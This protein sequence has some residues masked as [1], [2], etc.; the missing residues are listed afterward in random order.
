VKTKT[1]PDKPERAEIT[2]RANLPKERL[3]ALDALR[4]LTVAVM[5]M[6]NTSGDAQ[7][8][9]PILA[10]SRWN[11]SSLAD[12]VR[13][14]WPLT[15]RIHFTVP[16]WRNNGSRTISYS[17]ASGASSRMPSATP[18]RWFEPDTTS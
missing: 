10:H 1:L 11:G 17:K 5:I 12:V 9:F 6:V 13:D 16:P 3:M 15:G 7:H 4:G 8:T 14:V 18:A 2:P